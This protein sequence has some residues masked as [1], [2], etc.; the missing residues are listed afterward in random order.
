[1]E[2][3]VELFGVARRRAGT[4][5][6]AIEID[7]DE[8][9]FS[10]LLHILAERY[11]KLASSCFQGRRLRAGYLANVGGERFITD[12][13]TRLGNGDSLLIMSADAGG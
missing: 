5:C 1:M 10:D 3:T 7:A 8:V 2:I 11:P 6:V 12:P 13:Q 9:C 4:A